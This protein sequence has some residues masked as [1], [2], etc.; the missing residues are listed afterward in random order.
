MPSS[1]RFGNIF[2][3]LEQLSFSPMKTKQSMLEKP[4]TFSLPAELHRVSLLLRQ[5]PTAHRQSSLPFVVP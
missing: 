4:N 3:F 2:R 5:Q 1:P